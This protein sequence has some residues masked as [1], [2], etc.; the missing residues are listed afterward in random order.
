MFLALYDPTLLIGVA[1]EEGRSLLNISGEPPFL[2][3]DLWTG[4]EL[5]WLNLRGK[6]C[7]A[8]AEFFFSF[9][10]P[11]LI[12]SKSFKLYLNSLN[13]CKFASSDDFLSVIMTDLTRTCGGDVQI[14]LF[15]PGD[16]TVSVVHHL[17]G[18]S[19]DH[20]DV[21]TDVY[22]PTLDFLSMSL[23]VVSETLYTDLFRSKC[24][25]TGQP[26]WATVQVRYVGPQIDRKGLL[27]YFIS[28]RSHGAFHENCVE[29]IFMDIMTRCRPEKLTVYAR[30][31]RRGG[32]D[33]N[34]FRS[35][36]EGSLK[37]VWLVRQ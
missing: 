6:P 15:L 2:G 31:T 21:S 14:S 3:G 19:L 7:V 4:Y 9:D 33:I 13:G 18:I 26:D 28:Y 20:L 10:T 37:S 23:P 25:L 32:L 34:P 27:K 29:R 5:S 24:P 12:E 36:F 11:Y 30:F 22:V 1:R 8:M 35:N 17:A 16:D